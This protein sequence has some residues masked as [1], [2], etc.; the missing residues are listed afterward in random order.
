MGFGLDL[1][2]GGGEMEKK[3]AIREERE[4]PFTPLGRQIRLQIYQPQFY[5]VY[6]I[7]QTLHRRNWSIS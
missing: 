4:A 7:L 3:I 6:Y 5:S 2:W 1:W